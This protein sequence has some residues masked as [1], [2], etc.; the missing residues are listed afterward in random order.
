M[1]VG[2]QGERG[3][4]RRGRSQLLID[5]G[6]FVAK[7]SQDMY[8]NYDEFGMAT[9]LDA[10]AGACLVITPMMMMLPIDISNLQVQLV[11]SNFRSV[12]FFVT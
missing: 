3:R 11:R 12:S 6:S 9:W 7:N 5:H 2:A 4:E 8:T 1:A 10:A